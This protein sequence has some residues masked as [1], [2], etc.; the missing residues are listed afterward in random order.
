MLLVSKEKL[1]LACRNRRERTQETKTSRQAK[2]GAEWR[3]TLQERMLEGTKLMPDG[4]GL[5]VELW[6][7]AERLPV[8]VWRPGDA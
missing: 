3:L 4:E 8:K 1:R 2:S 6:P 7:T 5:M